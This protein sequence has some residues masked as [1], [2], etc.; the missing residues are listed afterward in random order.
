MR[1]DGESSIANCLPRLRKPELDAIIFGVW[2][3]VRQYIEEGAVL[4][5]SDSFVRRDAGMTRPSAQL[6]QSAIGD[7][8]GEPGRHLR[9]PF[10]MIQVF[11]GRQEGILHRVFSVVWIPDVTIC[12]SIKDWQISRNGILKFFYAR[13]TNRDSGTIFISHGSCRSSIF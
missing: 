3:E 6:A 5:I 8:G 12:H 4:L 7:D 13:L 1:N 10:K 2:P 11:A 9:R